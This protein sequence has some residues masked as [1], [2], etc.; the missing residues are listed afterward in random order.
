M[1]RK[2]PT[3]G[4]GNKNKS[5]KGYSER[6]SSTKRGYT[7]KWQKASKRYLAEHPLCVDCA[8]RNQIT[9]ATVVDHII[10]HRGDPVLFWDED[11]WQSMCKPDHD[12]KTGQGG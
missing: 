1:P 2:P 7:Y 3:H 8:E 6:K 11:N 4:T 5:R 10:P 9:A 12:K